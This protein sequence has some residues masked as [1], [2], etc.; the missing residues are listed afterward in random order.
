MGSH[1]QGRLLVIGLS[2]LALGACKKTRTDSGPEKPPASESASGSEANPHAGV[3][4]GGADDPHA[5]IPMGGG[6]GMAGGAGGT[7]PTV[8]ADGQHI[9]GPLALKIPP[10]WK[11]EPTTSGMRAAQWKVPAAKGGEAAELVA[12]YFGPNGAGTVAENIQ[13]WAEQFDVNGKPAQVKKS[14]RTIAGVP[15]TL[16]EL[17]GRFVA[18]MTP[19]ADAKHDKPD[20]MMLGV[21]IETKDGP[22]YYKLT[23]PKA[24]VQGV[25][26][27]FASM[28]AEIQPAPAAP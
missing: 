12:F 3:D 15:A 8:T 13:R 25:R 23:G 4:T 7:V 21:I 28:V 19:G 9:V 22:Y 1:R 18:A 6:G 26:A 16:V 10:A 24:T 20:H 14:T 11:A 2:L 17:E 5:G 27:Q